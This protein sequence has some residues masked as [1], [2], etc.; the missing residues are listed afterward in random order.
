[1]R[2]LELVLLKLCSCLCVADSVCVIRDIHC[3][4]GG[5]RKRRLYMLQYSITG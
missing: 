5:F 4:P 1:M 3:Q 2:S